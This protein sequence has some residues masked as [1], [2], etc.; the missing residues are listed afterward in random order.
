MTTTAIVQRRRLARGLSQGMFL[1]VTCAEDIPFLIPREVARLTAG[2]LLGDYRVRVQQHACTLWPRAPIPAGLRTPLRSAVPAL[3]I[4]GQRDPVTPPEFGERVM[5]GLPHG[6][7]VVVPYGGHGS[8]G[9]ACVDGMIAAFVE[10]GS[11]AG[12]D[13]SCLRR[14]PRP[15]FDTRR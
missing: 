8:G 11:A 3:L 7:H 2:T 5:R 15:R 6:L 12:L 1:S 10:R 9:G 4:S 14:V 13:T